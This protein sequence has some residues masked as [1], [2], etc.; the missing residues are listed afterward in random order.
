[1]L[2]GILQSESTKKEDGMQKPIS[3]LFIGGV[4]L[5]MIVSL[6]SCKI[7]PQIYTVNFDTD[8][9]S[10]VYSQYIQE[11]G[12]SMKPS[13]DPVKTGYEFDNW[14]ADSSFSLVWDFETPIRADKIGRASCR[15]RVLVVV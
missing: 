3:W 11:N 4:S 8:G 10:T 15:E 13:P 5:L 1:M 9:G 14:Y 12:K 6:Y 7:E 2:V